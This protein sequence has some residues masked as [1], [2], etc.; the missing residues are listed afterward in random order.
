MAP[1]PPASRQGNLFQ[2]SG[3]EGGLPW[4]GPPATEPLQLQAHQLQAWQERLSGHQAPLFEAAAQAHLGGATGAAAQLGL[5]GTAATSGAPATAA[6]AWQASAQ[7]DPEQEAIRFNPHSLRDQHLQFWRWPNPPQHGAALYLV[8]DRQARLSHPLLLYVGETGQADRRWKGEH[9]CKGY[10]AA[11]SE[12]LHGAGLNCQ[13]SIRFWSDV[14]AAIRPRR[15]LEQALI[16]RWQPPFN[17]ETRGR[18]AT[19]FTA[20]AD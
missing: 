20:L 5:F 15:A 3:P 8:L 6:P 18:W 14:P 1:A 7:A 19:P 9:D 4:A 17:K 16:R 11:Y 2:G 13:L 12:A 10:L